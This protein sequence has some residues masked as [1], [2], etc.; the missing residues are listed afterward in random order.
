MFGAPSCRIWSIATRAPR[1]TAGGRPQ[2]A[3]EVRLPRGS[4]PGPEGHRARVRQVSPAGRLTTSY[5]TMATLPMA[6]LPIPAWL[7][8]PYQLHYHGY[9]TQAH[10]LH[11]VLCFAVR[12]RLLANGCDSTAVVGDGIHRYPVSLASLERRVSEL[13]N[14]DTRPRP[15]TAGGCPSG[16]SARAPAGSAA[17][18]ST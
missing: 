10:H 15:M 5:I 18:T 7:H 8:Y 14:S 3:P 4:R 11:L 16:D 1:P 13:A 12:G 6:T 17:R 9:I 2:R